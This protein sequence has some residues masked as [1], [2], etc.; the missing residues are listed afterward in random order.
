MSL[1]WQIV[2][3]VMLADFIT[4]VVHWFEDTYATRRWPKPLVRWIVDPNI[5]HHMNPTEFTQHSF[6]YRSGDSLAIASIVCLAAWACG[7]FVW[8]F[9]AVAFCA[10]IGNEV[11]SWSHRRPR[12]PLFRFLQD[13]AIVQTP[14]QHAQHHRGRHNRRYCTLTNALNPALDGVQFW[15]LIEFLL[16]RIG[17]RPSRLTGARD[18]V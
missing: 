2:G 4:G 1:T 14:Q 18:F 7:M 10:A 11:H 9:T 16:A 5:R 13:A 17:L 6:L 15:T 3:C 8:Q 12:N